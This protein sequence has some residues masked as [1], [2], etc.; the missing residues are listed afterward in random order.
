MTII[1]LYES[2]VKSL[3]LDIDE[4]GLVSMVLDDQRYPC[5]IDGKR[6]AIPTQ[7]RL[8]SG[9]WDG[10]IA[11]HPLSENVARGESPV[12]KKLRALV[13]YRLTEVISTL[14]TELMELASNPEIHSKVKPGQGELL[15]VLSEADEKT[16]KGLERVLSSVTTDGEHR[17][18]SIYLK[19]GGR[20]M[21]NDYSR[22]AIADFPIVEEFE[23]DEPTIFGKKLSRKRDKKS[24]EKLFMYLLPNSDSF[25]TYSYG[26]NSMVAPYFHAL[27]MS[28]ATIAKQLN[29]I[30]RKMRS[31]LDNPK[32]IT[33]DLK[34]VDAMDDLKDYRDLIPVL[35]GNDGAAPVE[36]AAVGKDIS[37]DNVTAVKTTAVTK[38]QP[39]EV[40]PGTPVVHSTPPPVSVGGPAG[41]SLPWNTP[42]PK[43]SSS[44]S[45]TL[46]IEDALAAMMY[47][48]PGK[49]PLNR[50]NFPAAPVDPLGYAGRERGVPIAPFYGNQ[51]PQQ[52]VTWG[53]PAGFAPTGNFGSYI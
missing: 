7:K 32:A 9:E 31:H 12:I 35:E 45:N 41:V 43:S 19:H 50:N 52:G 22:V 36:R 30:T 16:L 14:M 44:A 39:Y 11:F 49:V 18:V 29:K 15:Q 25:E 23:S 10:L 1:E 47:P 37:A 21:T 2:I 51:Q 3:G 48:C 53:Q 34:W 28:Y 8:R 38:E 46:S 27:C 4:E 6:L 24:I 17:L 20:W 26:S 5:L 42:A 33:I 13:N 40:A